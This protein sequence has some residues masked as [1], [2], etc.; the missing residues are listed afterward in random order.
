MLLHN[1]SNKHP[2]EPQQ[3]ALH[4]LRSIT[5]PPSW[6][7]TP[8]SG[9]TPLSNKPTRGMVSSL[10]SSISLQPNQTGQPC[11]RYVALHPLRRRAPDQKGC[12]AYGSGAPPPTTSPTAKTFRPARSRAGCPTTTGAAL[13]SRFSPPGPGRPA[14]TWRG[15]RPRRPRPDPCRTGHRQ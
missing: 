15:E 8:L 12:N 9:V 1:S 5:P 11:T 7:N 6:C 4:Q 3:T 2:T 13:L 10:A 14:A